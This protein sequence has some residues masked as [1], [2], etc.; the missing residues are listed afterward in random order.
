[1]RRWDRLLDSY[2]SRRIQP[3]VS[4]QLLVCVSDLLKFWQAIMGA[5]LGAERAKIVPN[6]MQH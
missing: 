1:M 5:S 2:M 6:T 4:A 3:Q